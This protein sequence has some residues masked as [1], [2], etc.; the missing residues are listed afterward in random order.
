[1]Q[2][3]LL[4]GADAAREVLVQKI[5]ISESRAAYL[6]ECGKT[7]EAAEWEASVVRLRAKLADLGPAV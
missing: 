4:S 6:R 1:M 5:A 3:V 2:A 7:V